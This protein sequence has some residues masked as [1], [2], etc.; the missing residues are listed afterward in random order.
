MKSDKFVVGP[1]H[2]GLAQRILQWIPGSEVQVQ[3]EEADLLRS[4]LSGHCT[5]VLLTLASSPNGGQ[6]LFNKIEEKGGDVSRLVLILPPNLES[7]DV[8]TRAEYF[9]KPNFVY[10]AEEVPLKEHLSKLAEI[11]AAG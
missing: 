4:A 1:A 9:R 2:F 8:Y 6:W 11:G 5:A 10:P 7:A 3:V